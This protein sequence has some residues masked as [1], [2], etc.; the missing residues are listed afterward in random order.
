VA[1]PGKVAEGVAA[2]MAVAAAVGLG[3]GLGLGQEAGVSV[4]VKLRL[5]FTVPATWSRV[6]NWAVPLAT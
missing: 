1:K 3:L 2:G 5:L 4:P 6:L